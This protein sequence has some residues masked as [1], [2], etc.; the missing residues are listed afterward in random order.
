[1]KLK[2]AEDIDW[3]DLPMIEG[4][5]LAKT[6]IE[7]VFFN[8]YSNIIWGI[9]KVLYD[10]SLA[11]YGQTHDHRSLKRL[12][13]MLE[14]GEVFLVH[15]WN[16]KPFSPVVRGESDGDD[17]GK[18]RWLVLLSDHYL[19]AKSRLE[20]IVQTLSRERHGGCAPESSLW[21]QVVGGAKELVNQAIDANR[22][23]TNEWFA[24]K[25]VFHYS[26]KSTG[27]KLTPQEVAERYRNDSPPTL[28]LDGTGEEAGAQMVRDNPHPHF[29]SAPSP[30]WLAEA[31][32]SCETRKSSSKI[33]N[34]HYAAPTARQHPRPRHWESWA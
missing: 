11:Y 17:N 2:R 16:S 14:N 31:D 5:F 21:D 32:P 6:E 34:R 27:R 19:F 8:R 12:L 29:S 23:Q 7:R 24:E 33:C 4:P 22:A 20:S 10:S 28:N 3:Q 30:P 1:M 13:Q 26:D 18:G 25:G 9:D 15:G